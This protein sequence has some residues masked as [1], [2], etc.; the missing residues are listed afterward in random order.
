MIE[1]AQQGLIEWTAVASGTN[2]RLPLNAHKTNV[3]I[4]SWIEYTFLSQ[5]FGFNWP[6]RTWHRL[7]EGNTDF[8]MISQLDV[9]RYIA[10]ML[11]RDPELTK[12]KDVIIFTQRTST[13]EILALLEQITGEKITIYT[14]TPEEQVAMGVPSYLVD[15]RKMFN[16]PVLREGINSMESWKDKFPE[17]KP[18]TLEDAVRR[19]IKLAE[20]PGNI[21]PLR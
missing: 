14:E 7:G 16:D 21:K 3:R 12:N 15:V 4:G 8:A 20:E 2:H 9:G 6:E 1:K 10:A 19:G 11:L 18:L 5:F 17:V 13:N